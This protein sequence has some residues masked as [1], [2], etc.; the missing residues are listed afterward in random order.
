MWHWSLRRI[1]RRTI[2]FFQIFA[3]V[4]G[5]HFLLFVSAAVYSL[6]RKSLGDLYINKDLLKQKA[7]FK[8]MPF[9]R[10]VDKK[11]LAAQ[12]TKKTTPVKKKAAP[13]KKTPPKKPAIIKKKPAVKKIEPKK[14]VEPLKKQPPVKQKPVQK[15]IE[16][17]PKE[18]TKPPEKDEAILI[19]KDDLKL[20]NITDEI[21]NNIK[22]LWNP[23]AGIN[24]ENP[25]KILVVVDKK[26]QTQDFSVIE[27]SGVLAYDMAAQIAVSEAEFPKR[28][29]DHEF[30]LNF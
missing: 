29:W 21:L 9:V 30:T 24:P 25:C 22:D 20:L 28:V 19:G 2:F 15:K 6:R 11:K 23:P 13:K 5:I 12:L 10:H 17:K 14:K 8:V 27:S 16:Q 3:F 4:F 1:P 18:V 7:R 26:G